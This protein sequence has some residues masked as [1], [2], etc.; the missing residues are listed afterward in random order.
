MQDKYAFAKS[1]GDQAKVLAVQ[2]AKDKNNIE[3]SRSFY[4][5][6]N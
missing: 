1:F 2:K 6:K 5:I 4:G 3:T